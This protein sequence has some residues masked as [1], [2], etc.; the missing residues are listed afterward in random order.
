MFSDTG[1]ESEPTPVRKTGS[2]HES[3]ESD[4]APAAIRR[5]PNPVPLEQRISEA[6]SARSDIAPSLQSASH[7]VPK[8]VAHSSVHAP[9]CA[10]V[11]ARD[12]IL[13][14]GPHSS[15]P[16]PPGPSRWDV[17]HHPGS[18]HRGGFRGRG[19]GQGCGPGGKGK[20]RMRDSDVAP[21]LSARAGSE[22]QI[23]VV[24][25]DWTKR[26]FEVFKG[27][28][29]EIEFRGFGPAPIPTYVSRPDPDSF[30]TATYTATPTVTA[31]DQA[32][33]IV[34]TWNA[35]CKT[36]NPHANT[37]AYM[38]DECPCAPSMVEAIKQFLRQGCLRGAVTD[39]E[40]SAFQ[41]LVQSLALPN[42]CSS[43]HFPNPLV[44]VQNLHTALPQ[45]IYLNSKI[46]GIR[47]GAML[48]IRS[49]S[50]VEVYRSS[51]DGSA[52][53]F[54]AR[55]YGVKHRGTRIT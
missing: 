48:A 30:V 14:S 54:N 43:Y 21:A 5:K 15:S 32:E 23:V 1:S 53:K 42:I 28:C 37:M 33:A 3:S 17:N 27:F 19:G 6:R 4:H 18:S 52:Q 29:N 22:A 31:R 35:L 9:G 12:D 45:A 8:K 2:K 34:N 39:S 16:Y 49:G 38:R 47:S 44:D 36:S 13:A 24:K 11:S 26:S 51:P 41:L 25:V 20:A 46:S 7:A 10:A 50:L 55:T 40:S